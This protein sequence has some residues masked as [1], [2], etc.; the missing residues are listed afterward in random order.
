MKWS[1]IKYLKHEAIND[2]FLTYEIKILDFD[3]FRK[4]IYLPAPPTV[5]THH[6]RHP[7]LFD[8]VAPIASGIRVSLGIKHS[9]GLG[10]GQTFMVYTKDQCMQLRISVTSFPERN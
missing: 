7:G 9:T 2:Y 10:A 8:P 4:K 5:H 6:M 3:G 1:I